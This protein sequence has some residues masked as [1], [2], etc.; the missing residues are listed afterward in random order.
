MYTKSSNIYVIQAKRTAIGKFGKTFA[1]IS[2][3]DLGAACIKNVLE[4]S[5]IDNSDIQDVIIG[6]VLTAG[7]GQNP[8][9]QTALKA[10]LSTSIPAMTI[11]QV[12]AS[13]LRAVILGVQ[14]IK[15]N[16][17]CVLVGGQES[18]SN[19]HFS[20]Y[21]NR[22]EE[23]KNTNN[24]SNTMLSDGLTCAIKG[25]HM[26]ITAENLAYKYSISRLEQDKFAYNSQKKAAKAIAKN[27][28]K[29][30]IITVAG[31]DTDAHPRKISIEELSDLKAIFKKNGTVTV[32][33][34]SGI[35]DGAAMLLLA[36][37]SFI[38]KKNIQPLA[39]IT[40][41]GLSGVKP[42]IMGIGP[43]EAVK[44]AL[45]SAKWCI[46]DLDLIESNEAFA[47]QSI[48]VN[49]DLNWNTD[50]ININGGAIA[51][52]HPIGASGARILTTL[53]H[54][55]QATNKKKGIATLCVGGGMGVAV[56]IEAI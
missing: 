15:D 9:R 2:A 6:Q 37:L 33:N 29:N 44:K 46:D 30:E 25:Y 1:N 43:V 50:I 14:S 55:L 5:I 27:V 42:S 40:G 35:N 53:I 21:V 41:Y 39:K 51:L 24:L 17:D 16:F 22:K 20:G 12:C 7:Q 26:G 4:N 36:N 52:G 19:A 3:V 47:A 11:N 28:F 49:K 32:G 18:M 48:A 13:G 8:A 56:C 38:K 45:I 54:S 23:N 10:G 31:I 34:S